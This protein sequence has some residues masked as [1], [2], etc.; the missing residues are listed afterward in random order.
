[1]TQ[2]AANTGLRR[3]GYQTSVTWSSSLQGFS[4]TLRLQRT[5]SF[6]LEGRRKGGGVLES[7]E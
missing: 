4:E 6:L 1:M 7:E 2:E 5:L 3:D